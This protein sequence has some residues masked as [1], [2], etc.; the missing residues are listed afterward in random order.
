MT[1]AVLPSRGIAGTAGIY[2][3][4]RAGV[5]GGAQRPRRRA[6]LDRAGHVLDLERRVLEPEPLAQHRLQPAAHAVAV[7]ARRDEHVR[8]ST[9]KPLVSVQ[10]CR[11]CTS[12][13]SGTATIACATS[14]GSMSP[15][16]RLEED[17]RRLADQPERRPEHQRS[18]DQARDRVGAVPAGEQHDQAGDRGADEREQVGGHV[19][20]RA[21]H[22]QALAARARRAAPVATR[23]TAIAASATTSTMPPRTSTGETSRRIAPYTIQMPTSPSIRPFACAERISSRRNPY[24]QRPC[25]GR[26]ASVAAT[27]AKPSASDVGDQVPGVREQRERSGEDAGDDLADHRAPRSAPE[28]RSGASDRPPG[29]GRGRARAFPTG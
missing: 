2:R 6:E 9:G 16:R 13:T 18:D 23:L 26:A 3:P 14:S 8:E 15:G 10:T 29:G 4:L 17:A 27:T 24:V 5:A 22:V 12:R 1:I 11:S 7:G 21:A 19:Q 20:E 25:A 28:R